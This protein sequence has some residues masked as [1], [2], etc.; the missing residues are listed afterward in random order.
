MVNQFPVTD[1]I[2]A[3]HALSYPVLFQ[4]L[5]FNTIWAELSQ[6]RSAKEIQ[7]SN[8]SLCHF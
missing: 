1:C 2:N 7:L 5:S 6:A 4:E 3:R 8:L